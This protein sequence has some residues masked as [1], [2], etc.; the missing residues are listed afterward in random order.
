MRQQLMECGNMDERR[1]NA[2]RV[3]MARKNIRVKLP[4][5]RCVK[6]LEHEI[7]CKCDVFDDGRPF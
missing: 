2:E 1:A 3:E 7:L 6:C 5:S 4:P